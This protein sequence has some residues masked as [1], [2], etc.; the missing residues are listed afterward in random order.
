MNYI[1]S[2]TQNF[3]MNR[4]GFTMTLK[5]VIVFIVALAVIAIV[6]YIATNQSEGLLEFA[7]NNID[8]DYSIGS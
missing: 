7:K 3:S 6:S 2:P 4:K 5:M 1:N 8:L